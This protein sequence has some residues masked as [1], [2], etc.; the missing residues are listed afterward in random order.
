MKWVTPCSQQ[1][2]HFQ[3]SHPFQ[4]QH[5]LSDALPPCPALEYLVCVVQLYCNFV[6]KITFWSLLIE[7]LS[8]F[9]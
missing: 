5:H 4:A 9:Y 1:N 8:S 3:I 2:A 7:N 6:N